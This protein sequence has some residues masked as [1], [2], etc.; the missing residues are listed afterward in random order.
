MWKGWLLFPRSTIITVDSLRKQFGS[1]FINTYGL[2]S[3]I[4][5]KYGT[6]N[7]RGYRDLDLNKNQIMFLFIVLEWQLIVLLNPLLHKKHENLFLENPE[8]F[9]HITCLNAQKVEKKFLGCTGI[10]DQ[11][12]IEFMNCI[13]KK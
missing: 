8:K 1:M 12:Q 9:P 7:G 3:A 2:S 11:F 10:A 4:K 6:W 13:F 5:S